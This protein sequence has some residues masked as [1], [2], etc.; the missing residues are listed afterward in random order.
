MINV[1]NKT[2]FIASM[3]LSVTDLN[4]LSINI[5]IKN[6]VCMSKN[7]PTDFT[8]SMSFQDIKNIVNTTFLSAI[9]DGYNLALC[10]FFNPT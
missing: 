10:L 3:I 6:I 8:A 5:I 1:V 9:I 2:S 7:I 4:G